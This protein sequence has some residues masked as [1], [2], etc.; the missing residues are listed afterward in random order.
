MIVIA[1]YFSASLG[2]FLDFEGASLQVKL[3]V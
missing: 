3:D 2:V 1:P